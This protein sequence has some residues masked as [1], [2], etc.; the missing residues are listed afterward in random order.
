MTKYISLAG[1]AFAL[2]LLM[3]RPAGA[4]TE[5]GEAYINPTFSELT[6]TTLLLGGMD[7]ASPGVLD[8]YIQMM[9]CQVY[10]DNHLNDFAW[11]EI[12]K[13]ILSRINNKKEYYRSLFQLSGFIRLGQYDFSTR[14]FPLVQE[15]NLKNIG[16]MPLLMSSDPKQFC[17]KTVEA[18]VFAREVSLVL[19][20]PFNMTGLKVT[21]E[22]AQKLVSRFKNGERKLYIRFR[23]RVQAISNVAKV[24][25][26]Y[27]KTD[28]NG[29]ML[30]VDLFYDKDLT[31][32]YMSLPLR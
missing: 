16:Y 11:H 31:K 21:P 23:F 14:Q 19:S 4:V 17:G 9:Y 20:E 1:L 12:E 25:T 30:S 29:E 27:F 28:L 8:D 13:Q 18:S 2:V 3:M 15:E 26:H 22:E 24:G 32:W 5:A 10:K 6:Q 7:V